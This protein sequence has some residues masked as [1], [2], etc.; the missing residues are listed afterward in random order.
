[1]R[2]NHVLLVNG[3]DYLYSAFQL[4]YFYHNSWIFFSGKKNGISTQLYEFEKWFVIEI[5]TSWLK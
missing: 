1:M 2:K 5:S 4:I 3:I